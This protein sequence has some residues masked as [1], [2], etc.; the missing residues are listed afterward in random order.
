MKKTITFLTVALFAACSHMSS[1]PTATANL[2][3][4]SGSTAA[5]RATFTQSG[6]AVRLH[7]DITGVSAN[8]QHGFHVHEIGD[9]SSADAT[10]AGAHFNPTGAPHGGRTDTAHHAGD[11][12]NVM[13]NAAGE[14]RQDFTVDFISVTEGP[15]SVVGRSIV[16]HASPDDLKTQ[17]SGNSGA[18]I[19]CGVITLAQ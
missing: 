6:Q 9:C 1:G 3:S 18:R 14:I 10:S 2:E 15:S 16:L 7:L 5:G 19:A 17:P 13:S 11:F 8:T 4:R 12:G